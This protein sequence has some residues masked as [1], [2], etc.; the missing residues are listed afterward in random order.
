MK[1][2]SQ[3]TEHELK[4]IETKIYDV[5]AEMAETNDMMLKFKLAD[6]LMRLK[7]EIGIVKPPDSPYECEG[8]GA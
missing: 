1:E 6:E 4:A 8:C 7:K 5:E 2:L 3:L